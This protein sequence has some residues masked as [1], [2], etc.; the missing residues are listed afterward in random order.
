[1]P[2]IISSPFKIVSSS[3][4]YPVGV[5]VFTS[6][7]LTPVG[8]VSDT[9]SIVDNPTTAWKTLGPSEALVPPNGSVHPVGNYGYGGD[10]LL[11]N[12]QDRIQ[13]DST[14]GNYGVKYYFWRSCELVPMSIASVYG[15]STSASTTIPGEL[16]L[17]RWVDAVGNPSNDPNDP[18]GS[19]QKII[20]QGFGDYFWDGT[21]I[22]VAPLCSR[23]GYFWKL[24]IRVNPDRTYCYIDALTLTSGTGAETCVAFLTRMEGIDGSTI[25]VDDSEHT[26][27]NGGDVK[28]TMIDYAQG[29]TSGRFKSSTNSYLL[30]SSLDYSISQNDF[31]AEA[32]VKFEGNVSGNEYAVIYSLGTATN[33]INTLRLA[34]AGFGHRFQAL[35]GS[36]PAN[37]ISSASWTKTQFLNTWRHVA[38]SKVGGTVYAFIDGILIGSMSVSPTLT[39]QDLC[40]GNYYNVGSQYHLTAPWVGLMDSFVLTVGQGKYT[41]DFTPPARSQ[42]AAKD[43][44]LMHFEGTNNSQTFTDE[45]GHVFTPVG[46]VRITTSQSKYGGASG[47][48][49]GG[50]ITTP[51]TDSWYYNRDLTI[52]AFVRWNNVGPHQVLFGQVDSSSS[53]Y[54]PLRIDSYNGQIQILASSTS[55]AWNILPGALVGSFTSNIWYHI[56]LTRSGNTWRL[57]QDGTQIWSTTAA[58]IPFRSS[59]PLYIG[60]DLQNRYFNGCIDELRS[61]NGHALY[62]SNFIPPASQL[63]SVFVPIDPT[64]S[65]NLKAYWKMNESGGTTIT[66]QTGNYNISIVQQVGFNTGNIDNGIYNTNSNPK[67]HGTSFVSGTTDVSWSFWIKTPTIGSTTRNIIQQRGATNDRQY[68]IQIGNSAGSY[69][70]KLYVW[71]WQAS[72]T[73]YGL[74]MGSTTRIDNNQWHHIVVTRAGLVGKIY[75]DGVLD[76]TYNAPRTIDYNTA[77]E[78][79]MMYDRRDNTQYFSGQLD[80]FAIWQP[81]ALTLNEVQTIYQRGIGGLPL[82]T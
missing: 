5:D 14:V 3:C 74:Q 41:S 60:S 79:A 43:N 12:V 9:A 33:S 16:D 30:T 31:T 58:G 24:V 76:A 1:M 7:Y 66:D 70:G 46:N 72:G 29:E 42:L 75:I 25:V 34:D 10:A 6:A 37:I 56:A 38:V 23:V 26:V 80:D 81:R 52:E 44:L 78:F 57:F 2:V 28:L 21:E 67:I 18:S 48:F 45:R 71:D 36:D 15:L 17:Y 4:T 68:V 59:N 73:A 32:F 82:I 61:V 64:L 39:A 27:T 35:V 50:Y 20:D 40:I 47:E 22:T 53:S 11:N 13:L 77:C 55:G 19:W 63:T 65:T 51:S 49:Y 69:P 54:A 8:H 62:T